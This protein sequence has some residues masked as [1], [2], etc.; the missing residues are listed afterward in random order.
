[1]AADLLARVTDAQLRTAGVSRDE[2]V[3]GVRQLVGYASHAITVPAMFGAR[4]DGHGTAL[5]GRP[6]PAKKS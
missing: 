6:A 2:Y 3:A 1:L 4:Y 5:W